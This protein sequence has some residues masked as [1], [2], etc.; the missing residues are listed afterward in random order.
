MDRLV[1]DGASEPRTNVEIRG[2]GVIVLDD[3]RAKPP[4]AVSVSDLP[5]P[6]DRIA[7]DLKASSAG[8]MRGLEAFASLTDGFGPGEDK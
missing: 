2:A 6:W 1:V 8:R 5:P 7:A 4:A 3:F